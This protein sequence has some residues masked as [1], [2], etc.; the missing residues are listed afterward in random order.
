MLV[1]SQAVP[2]GLIQ[3]Y[4]FDL[5]IDSCRDGQCQKNEDRHTAR[6]TAHTGSYPGFPFAILAR[7]RLYIQPPGME[8][9]FFN[10]ETILEV[11]DGA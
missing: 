4:A 5:A 9:F 8:L 11:W 1:R 7:C 10:L 2:I 6:W 3:A